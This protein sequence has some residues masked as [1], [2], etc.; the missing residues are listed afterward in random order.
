MCL[1]WDI[2]RGYGRR[3]NCR[4]FQANFSRWRR[5]DRQFNLLM[6]SMQSVQADYFPNKNDEK[7]NQTLIHPLFDDVSAHFREN[8]ECILEG[9][10][11]KGQFHIKMLHLN[12]RQLISFREN[13]KSRILNDTH[14][15]YLQAL[16]KVQS[17]VILEIVEYNR[18]LE[19]RLASDEI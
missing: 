19:R 5:L 18:H 16:T 12:R 17:E 6:F 15:R 14:L 7:T 13:R 4:S 8:E 3:T 2:R 9:L 10:T 1:L 11:H